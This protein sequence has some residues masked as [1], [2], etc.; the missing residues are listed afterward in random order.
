VASHRRCR[1]DGRIAVR[2]TFGL[3]RGRPQRGR[4]GVEAED[5]LA[6]PLL[7]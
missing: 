5:D 2:V 7:D 6:A 1:P 3:D 4:V